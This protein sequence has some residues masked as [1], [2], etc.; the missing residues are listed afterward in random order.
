MPLASAL[1]SSG[2]N[3]CCVDQVARARGPN[4]AAASSLTVL[5]MKSFPGGKVREAAWIVISRSSRI[6]RSQRLES[7]ST[8]RDKSDFT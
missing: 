7:Q 2:G 3:D 1:S 4:S 6:E 5:F 8:D